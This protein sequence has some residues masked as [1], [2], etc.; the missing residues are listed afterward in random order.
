MV[1]SLPPILFPASTYKVLLAGLLNLEL[2]MALSLLP[3]FFSVDTCKVLSAD[4]L[5]VFWTV[6]LLVPVL[7]SSGTYKAVPVNFPSGTYKAVSA[8]SLNLV[9]SMVLALLLVPFLL[10]TH[11][12]GPPFLMVHILFVPE[13]TYN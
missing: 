3:S 13:H 12:L 7:F 8:D 2:S 5:T 10:D 11:N 4:Y 6:L 1:I 9:V